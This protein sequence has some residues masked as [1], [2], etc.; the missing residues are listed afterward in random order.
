VERGGQFTCILTHTSD[1]EVQVLIKANLGICFFSL[2]PP[3]V[4]E[5]FI[6][7][8]AYVSNT[9]GRTTEEVLISNKGQENQISNNF[10]RYERCNHIVPFSGYEI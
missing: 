4:A 8:D 6:S 3:R 1:P 7:T 5:F 2:V 9:E 10:S